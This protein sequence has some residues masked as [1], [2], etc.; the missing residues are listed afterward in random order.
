MANSFQYTTIEEQIKKLKSQHLLIENEKFAKAALQ[1]YGY[2]NIIN[3]YRDPFIIRDYNE[4]TYSPNVTFEE[5]Y[6]LFKFDHNVRAAVLLAMLDLEEH[7]KAAVAEIIA[8]DFGSDYHTYLHR[9]NYRDRKVSDPRFSRNKILAG[10]KKTAECSY[11]QPIRYY[12][13]T[14]GVIPPWILLKGVYFGTLVNY[15]KFFK[16][17][18]RN[19]L[20]R[21]IYGDDISDEELPFYKDMLSDTLFTCLEYRNLAAHEGR[22]YN[23]VLKSTIRAFNAEGIRAGLPQLVSALSGIKYQQPFV[24]IEE[25]LSDSLNEYCGAYPDDVLRLEKTLGFEIETERYVWVNERS[26]K[27]HNVAHCSGSNNCKKVSFEKIKNCDYVP[28]KKCCI[29]SEEKRKP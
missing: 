14:H 29:S 25:A 11:T 18:Q 17:K 5:I 20:I 21:A 28:C 8:E 16:S 10:M 15:I 23:H 2:Y 26:R 22:I 9:N 1:T 13:E 24:I 7:I 4:K 6:A 27:Y 3:G 19:K 12:R